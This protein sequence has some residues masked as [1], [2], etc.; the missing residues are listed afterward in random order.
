MA[1][2]CETLLEIESCKKMKLIAGKSAMGRS[3]SWPYIKAIDNLNEWLHGDEIVFVLD[4][5]GVKS[6]AELVSYVAEAQ[7]AQIT[8]L[9][10]LM[11]EEHSYE[12]TKK[13]KKLA[14]EANIALF[15]L[16]YRQKLIDITRDIANRIM[17]DQIH[18]MQIPYNAEETVMEMLLNNR[19]KKDVLFHC[20]R[21]LQALYDVDNTTKS[22]LVK[23]LSTYLH[24]GSDAAKTAEKLYIHRNTMNARL[25]KIEI[26]LNIDIS[27]AETRTEYMNVFR[28]L[29]YMERENF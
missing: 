26:L 2:T 1:V 11:D 14:E 3:I 13:V 17:E 27:D 22:E 10:F 28:T 19:D 20:Y 6:E 9:V 4:P 15:K 29:E 24:N 16:P 5:V 21:K 12:I 8:A 7:K 23:T 18:L 25:K